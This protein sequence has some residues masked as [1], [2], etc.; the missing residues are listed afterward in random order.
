MLTMEPEDRPTVDEIMQ[1]PWF[2]S[3]YR[4]DMPLIVFEEMEQRKHFII[5]EN[6]KKLMNMDQ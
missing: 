1:D 2:D 3:A 4:E 6:R 5:R